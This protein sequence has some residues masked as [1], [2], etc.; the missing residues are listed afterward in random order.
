MITIPQK[1]GVLQS[2]LSVLPR[3]IHMG[4]L[5]FLSHSCSLSFHILFL[6]FLRSM[7]HGGGGGG[8]AARWG[9]NDHKG[10]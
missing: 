1:S 8:S 3:H 9:S 4:P 6:I 10:R 7:A 5:H 2:S